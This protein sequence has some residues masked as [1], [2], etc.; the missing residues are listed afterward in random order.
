[1][2]ITIDSIALSGGPAARSPRAEGRR[3]LGDRRSRSTPTRCR[4][5]T[6]ASSLQVRRRR[7]RETVS[8]RAAST[9]TL[10]ASRAEVRRRV[11]PRRAARLARRRTPG[12]PATTPTAASRRRWCTRV[13]AFPRFTARRQLPVDLALQRPGSRLIEEPLVAE[14]PHRQRRHGGHRG[15]FEIRD[16]G[17]RLA[18][19]RSRRRP[20]RGNIPCQRG[21]RGAR[22]RAV[23]RAARR[24]AP[25]GGS[26]PTSPST[27]TTSPDA[28]A[29]TAGRRSR[30]PA[31]SPASSA[32]ATSRSRPT[33]SSSRRRTST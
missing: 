11:A 10:R 31:S 4:S 26:R 7:S 5:R 12:E 8:L 17:Q 18:G 27:A 20:A 21:A 3:R 2:S 30:R 29:R 6:S 33:T 22:R 14:H 16:Q 13:S 25:H 23:A 15:A 32:S 24:R 9:G 28:S 19:A 1:M